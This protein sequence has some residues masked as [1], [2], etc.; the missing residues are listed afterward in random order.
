M[1]LIAIWVL[2]SAICWAIAA[3]VLADSRATLK[4]LERERPELAKSYRIDPAR[5][6]LILAIQ[7]VNVLIGLAAALGVSHAG[8]RAPVSVLTIIGL[9]LVPILLGWISVKTYRHRHPTP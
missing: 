6:W 9:M 8:F 2:E 7:T 3:R 1:I 5:D 4:Y